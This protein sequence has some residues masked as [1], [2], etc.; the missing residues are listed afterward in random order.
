MLLLY[1]GNEGE[2]LSQKLPS[3]L[4]TMCP[5]T[6]LSLLPSCLY[7]CG[8]EAE[9]T[10]AALPGL[11]FETDNTFESF[12]T[13]PPA[14]GWTKPKCIPERSEPTKLWVKDPVLWG[15]VKCYTVCFVGFS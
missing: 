12:I 4:A 15:I 5:P 13:A 3:L 10:H 1:A 2:I 7:K 14:K 9:V 6:S 8:E 11:Y